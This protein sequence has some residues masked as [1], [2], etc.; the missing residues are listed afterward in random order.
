MPKKSEKAA[1]GEE[2]EEV[3]LR[4]LPLKLQKFDGEPTEFDSWLELALA[5]LHLAEVAEK[6]QPRLLLNALSSK[7]L[8]R[9]VTLAQSKGGGGIKAMVGG[10]M[11]QLTA[12]LRVALQAPID[13][14]EQRL[15]RFAQLRLGGDVAAFNE[16]FLAEIAASGAGVM[17]EEEKIAFYFQAMQ[18]HAVFA[19]LVKA[20]AARG[21][22]KWT[23]GKVMAA[24]QQLRDCL[25]VSGGSHVAAVAAAA[26]PARSGVGA[27]EGTVNDI[28]AA[29]VAAISRRQRR[30]QRHSGRSGD[31]GDGGGG[32]GGRG[33][34]GGLAFRQARMAARGRGACFR[35]GARDHYVA[36][37]GHAVNSSLYARVSD[38]VRV[39]GV[40]GGKK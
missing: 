26:G 27:A 4:V 15:A 22:G 36:E 40:G 39:W 1:E 16:R 23:L 29:V 10:S 24:A 28:A 17:T 33:R 14:P 11:E 2:E 9:V 7:T 12:H 5:Q 8:Q 38:S 30:P 25:H 35:C 31:D 37:C 19:T 32:G 34:G 6:E 20:E 13:T 21:G 3:G 18:Q